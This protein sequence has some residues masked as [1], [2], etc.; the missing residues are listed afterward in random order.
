[1]AASLRTRQELARAFRDVGPKYNLRNPNRSGNSRRAFNAAARFAAAGRHH[2]GMKRRAAR[3]AMLRW[4][5]G[6]PGR[7]VGAV[8]R[9]LGRLRNT[10]L[11]A[12]RKG[13]G[14]VR[15]LSLKRRAGQGLAAAG[16]GLRWTR[17][18]AASAGRKGIGFVR[19]LSLKRRAGQGLAAVGRGLGRIRNRALSAGKK[20]VG[21]VRGLSLKRRAKNA[22][23]GALGLAALPFVALG[24]GAQYLGKKGKNAKN[25]YMRAVRGN[26]RFTKRN[27]KGQLRGPLI[28]NFEGP[29]AAMRNLLTGH[30]GRSAHTR[31]LSAK[32]RANAALAA[33]V[34][35][36]PAGA[37]PAGNGIFKRIKNA[38]AAATRK[39]KSLFGRKGGNTA[40]ASTAAKKPWKSSVAS[41]LRRA[42]GVV[43][44]AGHAVADGFKGIPGH[45]KDRR[46]ARAL[47]TAAT[48]V[49]K[50]APAPAS[51]SARKA[52]GM[53]QNA[54]TAEQLGK[55]AVAVGSA[56]KAASVKDKLD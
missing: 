40:R 41:G 16:R 45:Y 25:A 52:L 5:A 23:Y 34:G 56:V 28:S 1:M 9:G 53:V 20:G 4:L 54:K 21:F 7:G 30:V 15:G 39:I 29:K 2:A 10:A 49:S 46:A 14:F 18:R 17:N 48:L 42:A 31:F 6:L 3:E 12:G 36:A 8:G 19:G 37:A 38:A 32:G 35:A 55:A 27:A 26:S 24:K 22:A 43:V 50:V 33:P 44:N 13:V 47:R 51:N 11:S